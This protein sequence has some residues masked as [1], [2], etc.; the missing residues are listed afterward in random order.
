MVEMEN[1]TRSQA[2]KLEKQKLNPAQ[3]KSDDQF[4][5]VELPH[6]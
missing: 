3:T 6:E 4:V 5:E 2:K 1:P